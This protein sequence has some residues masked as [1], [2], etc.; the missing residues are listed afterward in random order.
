MTLAQLR[1]RSWQ[2]LQAPVAPAW[3]MAA[4]GGAFLK[5]VLPAA[6]VPAL[7]AMTV[8]G[9]LPRWQLSQRL[10]VGRWGSPLR[11]CRVTM[12]VMPAKLVLPTLAPW[13]VSQPLV[14]PAWL[15]CPPAKVVMPVPAPAA[16]ISMAGM[17]LVWQTVQ[18]VLPK[19]RW[20]PGGALRLRVVRTWV[21]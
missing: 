11:V 6:V 2:L 9:V 16:G 4:V 7:A 5:R 8:L 18:S 15:I 13:Q 1:S 14:M 20:L 21:R 17:L 3:I 19:G 12:R 10:V